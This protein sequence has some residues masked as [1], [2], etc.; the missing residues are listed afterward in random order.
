MNTELR[1]LLH[2]MASCQKGAHGREVRV[3]NVD[4]WD[5]WCEVCGK[6]MGL[7]YPG[8]TARGERTGRKPTGGNRR[9]RTASGAGVE[10]MNGRR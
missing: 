7:E 1:H 3:H 9:P 10:R 5:L 8:Q 2:D 6:L 4:H